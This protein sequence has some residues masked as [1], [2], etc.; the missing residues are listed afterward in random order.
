MLLYYVLYSSHPGSRR[1]AAMRC[2]YDIVAKFYPFGQFCEMIISLLSLETQPNTAPN[3]VQRGVEYGEYEIT[4]NRGV[5]YGKYEITSNRG[6][7][8]GKYEYLFQRG[9]EYGEYEITSNRGFLLNSVLAIVIVAVV[10]IAIV[11]I[12]IVIIAIV[13]IAIINDSYH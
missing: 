11:M 12:A 7:E 4:S 9:V 1:R 10:I 8:Y 3:L 5:E 6:V 13:I 2:H